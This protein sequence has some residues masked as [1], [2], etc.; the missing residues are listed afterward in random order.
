MELKETELRFFW[1]KYFTL[2]WKFG[3]FLAS[4]ICIPRFLLVLRAN[5]IGNYN[6]IGIIM[7]ISA[8]IPF[9]FLN[10]NG[11][12]KMGLIIPKNFNYIVY[13]IA[14]GILAGLILHFLGK[15]FYGD[16]NQNWYKYISKSYKI[17][18]IISAADKKTMFLV[19]AIIASTYSP[20]GEEFFFRGIVHNS[21]S[22]SFGET[23]ASNID[24]AIFAI[25][26]IAHFG[27]IYVASGWQFLVAPT[28]FW[29]MAMFFLS[30]IFNYFKKR[31]ESIWGAVICHAAFNI[32]MMYAIFYLMN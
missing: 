28:I 1:Q 26:H 23:M 3:V 10:K 8:L 21:F 18:A 13:A 15:Y 31:T 25:T 14:I 2:N 16:T 9:I 12:K 30:K 19:Y 5:Q 32:T 11:L 4:I 24:S 22:N 29:V 20:I 7:A 6:N 17:P 27:L